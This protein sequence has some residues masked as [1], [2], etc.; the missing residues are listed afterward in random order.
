[1]GKEEGGVAELRPRDELDRDMAKAN[2]ELSAITEEQHQRRLALLKANEDVT[3]EIVD[4]QVEIDRLQSVIEQGTRQFSSL[5]AQRVELQGHHR[6][7]KRETEDLT[8]EDDSLK[9]E[10]KTLSSERSALDE[11]VTR[12]KKLKADYLAALSKFKPG[13]TQ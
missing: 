2:K 10:N 11:E 13:K 7:L 12:L 1:M 8:R 3:R 5:D 4:V 9:D 6:R